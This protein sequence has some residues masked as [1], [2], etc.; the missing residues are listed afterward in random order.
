MN[1]DMLPVGTTLHINPEDIKW[2]QNGGDLISREALKENI[3][4]AFKHNFNGYDA[5]MVNE[6]YAFIDN[7]PTVLFPLTVKIKD[8]VTDEDIETLKRLMADYKPQILNLETEKPQGEQCEM[9]NENGGSIMTDKIK[10]AVADEFKYRASQGRT[11][12]TME[13]VIYIVNEVIDDVDF[14]NK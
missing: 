3:K 14:E 4:N 5:L 7:A 8:N 6:V 13:E 9:N 10:Q 12:Y 11:N 1:N 2:E